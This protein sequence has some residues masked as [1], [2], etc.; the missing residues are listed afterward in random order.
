MQPTP[1]V[2][3]KSTPR[4]IDIA[5]AAGVGIATVN[6]VLNDSGKASASTR[7]KVIQAARQLGARRV[8]PDVHRGL[9]RFDF[10]FARSQTPFFE[11]LQLALQRHMQLLDRRIVVHR[12]AF[13]PADEAQI[14]T[15]IKKPPH[16]RNGLIVVVHDTPVLREAVQSV[17]R[18]G[19]PVVTL[20]S[21]LSDVSNLHYAGI[22]NVQA[23]RSAGYFLGR[24]APQAGRVLVL[25][26]DLS[27]RAHRDR[28]NGFIAALQQR[29]AHLDCLPVVQT[30]DD[31]DQ[32]FA[33]VDA[34]IRA[35]SALPL[36]GI[37]NSGAGSLGIAKA[38]RNRAQH[39]LWLGHELTDEH[40]SYL[41]DGRMDLVIDQDP[42]GQILSG[43]QYLLHANKW[44]DAMP[45]ARPT[46]FRLY[47]AENITH[48]A[49][50]PQGP[51][52]E[53]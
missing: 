51:S 11:R 5:T 25:T 19:V 13:D 34:Q 39:V 28:T 1:P 6:R 16:R 33:A 41:V 38:L 43:M 44:T 31:A 23:G 42:D 21:D 14:A 2:R 52:D 20:M 17:V 45:A 36:C 48:Q 4:L 40:R 27:F 50:L 18:Q 46:D 7:E 47:C 32:T 3:R 37:Y 30:H 10:V 12:H 24:L 53:R 26:N 35:G 49:Y 29:F 9:T 22:N 8:M 15:F